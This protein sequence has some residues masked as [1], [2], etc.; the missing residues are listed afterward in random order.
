MSKIEI[1]EPF[2]FVKNG[3]SWWS[4]P[5]GQIGEYLV[6]FDKKKYYYFFRDWDKLTEEQ[7]NII[8]KENPVLARLKG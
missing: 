3:K 5:K 1:E 6:S 2:Q 7:K 4:S 8:R